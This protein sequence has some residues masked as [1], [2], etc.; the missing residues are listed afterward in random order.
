MMAASLLLLV[1]NPVHASA[2]AKG[3]SN[4]PPPLPKSAHNTLQGEGGYDL[5][6]RKMASKFARNTDI[7]ADRVRLWPC[8]SSDTRLQLPVVCQVVCLAHGP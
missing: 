7:E 5:V 1:A 2:A 4:Q 3:H 8:G 6:I